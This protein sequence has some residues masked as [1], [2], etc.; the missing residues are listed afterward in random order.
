MISLCACRYLRDIN[1]SIGL[2]FLI[3]QAE[4]AYINCQSK[5]GGFNTLFRKLTVCLSYF[6]G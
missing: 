4:D 3:K 1:L 6:P 5:N 2:Q